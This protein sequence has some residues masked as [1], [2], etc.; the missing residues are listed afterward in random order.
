MIGRAGEAHVAGPGAAHDGGRV[1]AAGWRVGREGQG[2]VQSG[3]VLGWVRV[4]C[5]SVRAA[6]SGAPLWSLISREV[7]SRSL[8]AAAR[9]SQMS[10]PI[11]CTS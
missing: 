7:W 4:S 5:V 10:V 8:L 6:C 3:G 9:I 1:W 2:W 11:W